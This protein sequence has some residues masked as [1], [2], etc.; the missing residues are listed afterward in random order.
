M[1]L[2]KKEEKKSESNTSNILWT[3]C[4]KSNYHFFQNFSEDFQKIFAK[5]K[6]IPI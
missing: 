2:L 3:L 5:N 1:M 4:T 6:K